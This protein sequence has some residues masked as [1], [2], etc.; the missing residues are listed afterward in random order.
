[1]HDDGSEACVAKMQNMQAHTWAM[2]GCG[3]PLCDPVDVVHVNVHGA[4]K[5]LGALPGG[6]GTRLGPMFAHDA[7]R[8]QFVLAHTHTHTRHGT[9]THKYLRP[10]SLGIG[11]KDELFVV[12]SHEGGNCAWRHL[13]GHP[14]EVA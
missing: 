6:H 14:R 3:C 10:S 2:E 5:E 13:M 9:C 11:G 12:I 4:A 7:G 8:M 1:V